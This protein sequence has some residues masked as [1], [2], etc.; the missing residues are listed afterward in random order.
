MWSTSF[1]SE[2]PRK[3]PGLLKIEEFLQGEVGVSALK[4]PFNFCDVGRT[5]I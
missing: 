4:L 3:T 2:E 5:I 1:Y